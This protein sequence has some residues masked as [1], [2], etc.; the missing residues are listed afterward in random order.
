MHCI[1]ITSRGHAVIERDVTSF[2]LFFSHAVRHEHELD[3]F[4]KAILDYRLFFAR[5]CIKPQAARL[6]EG[7]VASLASRVRE[8]V[9]VHELKMF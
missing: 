5:R 4:T 8:C 9:R 1:D 2:P 7:F 3:L 6:M